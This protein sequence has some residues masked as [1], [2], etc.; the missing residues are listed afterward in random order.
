MEPSASNY[1]GTMGLSSRQVFHSITN[2]KQ[3]TRLFLLEVV[4]DEEGCGPLGVGRV[5]RPLRPPQR[6]PRAGAAA[7]GVREADGVR[8]GE[9]VAVAQTP[10]DQ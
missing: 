3:A 2:V 1:T 7:L 4:V 8:A 5:L 6:A 9:L 10:K